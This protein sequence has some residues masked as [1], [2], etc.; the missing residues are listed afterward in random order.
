MTRD[1]FIMVLA[2]NNIDPN[3]VCFDENIRMAIV[4]A[5]V[6]IAGKHL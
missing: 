2:E 4:S 5:N 6:I 3:I 1:E